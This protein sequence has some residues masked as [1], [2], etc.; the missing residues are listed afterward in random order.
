MSSSEDD[1]IAR[2]FRPIAG[3]G[4]L[5]LLDDAARLTPPPGHDLVL[6]ADAL[7]AGV[8]F[9]EGDPPASI[10]AKALRVNLS[11]LAAKGAEPLGF[12]LTIALTQNTADR[13]WL[14]AFADG[15]YADTETYGCPLLGGDTVSTPGPL[16]LSIT[17]LGVVPAGR[18][19]ARTTARPGDAILVSGTIGDGAL[20]LTLRL[21]PEVAWAAAL[22]E[23]DRGHLLDRYLH[24]RPRNALA[25]ALRRHASAAMDVSDGLAGDA[26]KLLEASGLGGVVDFAR[27][28]LSPA[29]RHA[30]ELDPALLETAMT[31]GDDFEILAT[32]PQDAVEAFRAEA[33][34]AGVALAVI[35]EAGQP[36]EPVVLRGA[37]GAQ[38]RYA[39]L[40]YSHL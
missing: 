23:H 19:V 29:A 17:A 35:G 33:A 28:P 2:I 30:I 20:G 16:S 1:L 5:G 25:P 10:A 13:A 8:H 38:V 36:G 4:A 7:V 24:P 37:G 27:V 18:M 32:V 26:A 15:L 31:G 34:E 22:S 3:E 12:L 6:T 11:D 39:R 40:S 9:F 14:E 21:A